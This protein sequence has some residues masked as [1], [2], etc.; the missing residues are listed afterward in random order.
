MAALKTK[1]VFALTKYNLFVGIRSA[2][3]IHDTLAS[4]SVSRYFSLWSSAFA[5]PSYSLL[6]SKF[7]IFLD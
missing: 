7:V 2:C 6:S 3:P 4:L 5:K 1:D